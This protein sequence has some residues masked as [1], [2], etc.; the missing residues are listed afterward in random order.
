M[1]QLEFTGPMDLLVFMYLS[2]EGIASNLEKTI[3]AFE[4]RLSSD[5]NLVYLKDVRSRYDKNKNKMEL[6]LNI[7]ERRFEQEERRKW[8]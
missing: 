6:S 7:D 2:I 4:E 5:P 3:I 1:K 8:R